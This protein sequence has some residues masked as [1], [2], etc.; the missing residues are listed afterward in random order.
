V[1]NGRDVE[2]GRSWTRWEGGIGVREY[3][4]KFQDAMML[5]TEYR[6]KEGRE[7]AGRL[8]KER[9]WKLARVVRRETVERRGEEGMRSMS[10]I[11]E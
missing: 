1:R 6:W 4:R 10:A 7:V 3:F 5:E 2:M 11:T 8:T 9:R